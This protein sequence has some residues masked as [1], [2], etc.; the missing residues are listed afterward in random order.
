MTIFEKKI[1]NLQKLLEKSKNPV[2]KAI[3]ADKIAKTRKE[4]VELNSVTE[5]K[6]VSS[7]IDAPVVADKPEARN[8]GDNGIRGVVLNDKLTSIRI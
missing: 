1:E 7:I 4:M 8:L 6:K 5:P 3:I 2:E